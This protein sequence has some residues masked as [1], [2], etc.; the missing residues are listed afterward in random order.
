MRIK[1][2]TI[3]AVAVAAIVVA[4]L[5]L[6]TPNTSHRG[7]RLTGARL[8]GAKPVAGVA[9]SGFVYYDRNDNGVRDPGE[10]GIAGI[11]V[12]DQKG[13]QSTLTGS[14]GG[15]AFIAAPASGF[16]QVETGW[17]RSQCPPAASPTATTCPAGPGAD[18]EFLVNNQFVQYPLTGRSTAD[19]NV[20]LVPD[21]PGTSMTI[22]DPIDGEVPANPVDVAARLSGSAGTCVDGAYVI[23]TAGS[24]FTMIAQV[25]NQGTTALTGIR[26]RLFVPPGD[27]ASAPTIAAFT[28]PDGLGPLTVTPSAPTC[29][30]RYLDFSLAGDL[31]PAGGVRISV[32]GRTSTG[33]G[34]PGCTIKKTSAKLCPT[35]EPQGR[36]WLFG[37]SH[38]DQ[39]GDP[40]STFCAAG[41]MTQC[42]LGLHDKRRAPDEIDPA[43]HNVDA[44]LGG[45]PAYDLIA[46]L[47]S[48]APT[49]PVPPGGNIALRAWASDNVG[50][51]DTN[52]SPQKVTVKVFLPAGTTV[53]HGPPKHVLISCDS[54]KASGV[55]VVV[56]C[57]LGGPVAP[58][59][60]S[61]AIDLTVA[62]PRSWPVSKAFP[63][64]A[65]VAPPAG[66]AAET[67]P[68]SAGCG[69]NTDPATTG[70][71]NDASISWQVATS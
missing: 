25:Y 35:E 36:G 49:G 60:S 41:D 50:S 43:G 40:D 28:V 64:V 30:T 67:V 38:I 31:V 13:D 63:A 5:F 27:C 23:C 32:V 29:A 33:P 44:A 7:T 21:W 14:D 71:D 26:A 34:T 53:L 55:A 15:Y 52:A 22:P 45:T 54:G 70:T 18:N 47:T 48:M 10:P 39:S 61:P 16:L 46:H 24:T 58:H 37:I 2:L 65:C 9:V 62:V 56:T 1:R 20:G 57:T 68:A 17:F 8:A 6:A 59:L 12:R 11:A 3:A 42:P 66:G 4:G 19:A 51:G 69:L